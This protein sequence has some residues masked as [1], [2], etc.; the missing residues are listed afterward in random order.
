MALPAFDSAPPRDPAIVPPVSTTPEL[1]VEKAGATSATALP[2]T[3]AG[4]SR[5]QRRAMMAPWMHPL[6]SRLALPAILALAAA[7]RLINLA[8]NPGWDGDEGYNYNIALNLAQGRHQMFALDFAFVQHPPLYFALAAALFH[9]L[10]ASM[11]TLRLL[12]ISF[13]LGTLALLPAL[14]EAMAE[15]GGVETAARRPRRAAFAGWLAAVAYT[16]WPF[17]AL[18]Q[19]FGYTY[20]GLAFWTALCLLGLLRYRRHPGRGSLIL[21]A[22]ACAAALATDQ[23][24]LYL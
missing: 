13:C 19:R 6:A 22:L 7:L 16:L 8:S 18:Q 3:H 10:G 2:S 20:N 11:L 23:E 9:L 4:A 5:E 1:G 21:A 24:A 12:S 14:G 17:A 15:P